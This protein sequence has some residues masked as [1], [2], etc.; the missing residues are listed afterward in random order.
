[1]LKAIVLPDDRA[2]GTAPPPGRQF[3]TPATAGK[4]RGKFVV[5]NDAKI[6]AQ[7]EIRAL[8]A[9]SNAAIA[10]HQA[11]A[12]VKVM[13]DGVKIITSYGS[14]VDGA[15]AMAELFREIF[16]DDAFVTFSREPKDIHIGDGIAAE[17]GHWTGTWKHRVVRGLYLARWQFKE[18]A[19][20]IEA[21]CFVPL[22]G[23]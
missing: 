16:A 23:F 14:I 1:M 4:G 5:T 20:R 8:R 2:V 11:D 13:S 15:N 21:E 19:W 9:Q 22:R 17:E 10:R 18:G 12:A 7:S 6:A 3:L